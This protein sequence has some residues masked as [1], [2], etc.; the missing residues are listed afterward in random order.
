MASVAVP[1]GASAFGFDTVANSFASASEPGRAGVEPDFSG[2][3]CGLGLA[4]APVCLATTDVDGESAFGM[5]GATCGVVPFGFEIATAMTSSLPSLS[6]L[7]ASPAS[8]GLSGLSR[9]SGLPAS[10]S[11]T[12]LSASSTSI[13]WLALPPCSA[14]SSAPAL[15]TPFDAGS[16][17]GAASPAA[18]TAPSPDQLTVICAR[19]GTPSCTS[20]AF[21]LEGMMMTVPSG[22]DDSAF[23]SSRAVDTP[24]PFKP[25]PFVDLSFSTRRGP[26]SAL[27]SVASGSTSSNSA[28]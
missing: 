12:A 25:V 7:S 21:T 5:S 6:A 28:W 10:A 8:A 16:S 19:A 24:V 1:V 17:A 27:A 3:G 4:I 15:P 2:G 11:A 14:L 13:A 9:L 22:K 18:G 20:E 26:A 23:L